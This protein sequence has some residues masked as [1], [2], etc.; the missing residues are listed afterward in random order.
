MNET[1]RHLTGVLRRGF[2]VAGSD[3]ALQF[4]HGPTG[5]TLSIETIVVVSICAYALRGGGKYR[6]PV[7]KEVCLTLADYFR[8]VVNAGVGASYRAQN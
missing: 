8:G 5:C 2:N 6:L 7:V 3:D 1:G 4:H